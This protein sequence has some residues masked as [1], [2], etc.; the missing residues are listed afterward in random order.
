M[1]ESF[2]YRIAGPNIV[3]QLVDGEVVAINMNSGVYYSL[4]GSAAVVWSA[5]ERGAGADGIVAEL[6]A[7]YTGPVLEIRSAVEAFLAELAGESLIAPGAGAAVGS[8]P[9]SPPSSAKP[10]F[11]APRLEKFSDMS[12]MLL[13]D[14]VHDVDQQAGWPAPKP[15]DGRA[16]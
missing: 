16:P 8:A 4:Q 13:L 7:R 2:G 5:V 11:Q 9:A 12:Q 15:A 1:T 3:H 14:P 10:A 6:S